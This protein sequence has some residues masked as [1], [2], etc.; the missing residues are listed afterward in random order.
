MTI[1]ANTAAI[2]GE[3]GDIDGVGASTA[4]ITPTPY[5]V[6]RVGCA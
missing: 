3:I 2:S 6:I 1:V 5:E 4:S